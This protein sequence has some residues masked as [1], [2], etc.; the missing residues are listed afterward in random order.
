MKKIFLTIALATISPSLTAFPIQQQYKNLHGKARKFLT[1]NSGALGTLVLVGTFYAMYS[2][3]TSESQPSQRAV[4]FPTLRDTNVA[5]DSGT[6]NRVVAG[7]SGTLNP[8]VAEDTGTMREIISNATRRIEQG[9]YDE[10]STYTPGLRTISRRFKVQD[11]TK[12]WNDELA[13]LAVQLGL[14]PNSAVAQSLLEPVTQGAQAWGLIPRNSTPMNPAILGH[15]LK[16]MDHD[17]ERFA[18]LLDASTQPLPDVE[19]L[20]TFE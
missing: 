10:E 2:W 8:V 16:A 18:Q 6:V 4:P 14:V 1:E 15:L 7:D 5:G 3:Y 20:E 12:V 19:D 13:A 9:L 11:V 17:P